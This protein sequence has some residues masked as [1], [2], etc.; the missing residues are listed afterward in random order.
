MK[1]GHIISILIGTT[2]VLTSNAALAAD[3]TRLDSLV[4]EALN[5]NPQ[6]FGSR[7][8][9][10]AEKYKITQSRSLP[11]P[12]AH[13]G[14]Y[15][16][17]V[18]TRVGPMK[19]KVG[20]SQKIPF[21]AKLVV[22][23]RSQ[24]K[25]AEI[26]K[27]EYEATERELIKNVKLVYYDIYWVDKAIQTTEGEKAILES[28]E[29]VAKKRYESKLAPL[30]DV[31]KTQVAISELI[32]KLYT[33]NENRKSFV[34]Q[35]NS[36]L[37]RDRN[38]SFDNVVNLNTSEFN[39][40][41]KDLS[42]M[43]GIS[44]QELKGAKIAIEKAQNERTLAKLNYVPDF[45]FGFDYTFI[46]K[47]NIAVQNNGKDAWL[48]T[49]S[50]NIPIWLNK[51][52]AQVKEKKA[53]LQAAK[54][55]Y[56]DTKNRV[57]YEVESLYYRINSGK[58]VINLYKNALIPQAQQSFDAAKVGYESGEVDFL[59]WLDSERTLLQVRLTYYKAVADYQKSIAQMERVVGEDL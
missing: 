39:H 6:I 32:E 46:D 37:N 44:R 56:V 22:Q 3:K 40:S 36:L 11:D 54:E 17:S 21:P 47:G 15:G 27:E 31:I 45:T 57:E 43:A 53:V 4:D 38:S 9:W 18:E 24:K 14:Y 20:A 50:L 19:H 30:Q 41:L 29:R 5:N 1:I 51:I 2:F 35:M 34:S 12:T 48:G 10:E 58:D 13:Y 42:G 28:L 23:G 26:F 25:S 59:N 8:S 49:V 33:L 7:S 52:N 55:N 16:E